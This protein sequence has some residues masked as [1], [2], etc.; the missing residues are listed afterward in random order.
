MAEGVT[1]GVAAGAALPELAAAA[2]VPLAVAGGIGAVQYGVKEVDDA[3]FGSSSTT[4]PV[5]PTFNTVSRGYLPPKPTPQNACQSGERRLASG[6]CA[7]PS[8]GYGAPVDWTSQ[9][10]AQPTEYMTAPEASTLPSVYDDHHQLDAQRTESI[11]DAP[12]LGYF[13]YDG[14]QDFHG[15]VVAF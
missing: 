7:A 9:P 6:V 3:L 4:A 8:S 15:Q 10:D 13:I 1:A 11:A 14:S 2:A 5:A 12:P